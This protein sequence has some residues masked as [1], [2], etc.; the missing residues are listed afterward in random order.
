[1]FEE[2][3]SER[4]LSLDRLRVLVEVH[5]AGSIAQAAPGDPIRQ[6]Q[7][8][9]QLRELAEFFGC[10]VARR[11][12]KLLKLTDRGTVLAG[13]ART[14][15][16]TLVDFR[17]DCRAEGVDYTLAA[18]DSVLHWLVIPRLGRMTADR[19]PVHF[20]TLNLRTNEVVQQLGDGRVEFGVVRQDAVP[21][22]LDSAPLGEVTYV[23]VVPKGLAGA[24]QAP[25]LK[26]VLGRLPL[27]AQTADGQFTQ[28]L[29]EIAAGLKVTLRPRLAC[30]TFPQT[31]SAVRSGRFAAILPRLALD[32]LP[33]DSCL[34]LGTEGLRRLTRKLALA[35]NP[36]LTHVRPGANRLIQVLRVELKI[37]AGTAKSGNKG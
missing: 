1:M 11:K 23:A 7:Y 16:R 8:S 33:A 3:F 12:G 37:P 22:A 19:P 29:R 2:L 15:L 5:D 9:R 24:G 6:S 34:I 35:W 25:T 26:D 14:H 13:L 21:P 28:R 27:A 4:G 36:R 10:E 32:E 17:A 18:G 20:A 30:Q 31:L